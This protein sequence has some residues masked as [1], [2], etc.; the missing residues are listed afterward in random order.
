MESMPNGDPLYFF[1]DTIE[2]CLQLGRFAGYFARFSGKDKR[3]QFLVVFSHFSRWLLK[4]PEKCPTLV[5]QSVNDW[6]CYILAFPTYRRID[7]NDVT[8]TSLWWWSIGDCPKVSLFQL[9]EVLLVIHIFGFNQSIA[10]FSAMY[11]PFIV[12]CLCNHG[13]CFWIFIDVVELVNQSTSIHV[14]GHIQWLYTTAM[15]S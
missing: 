15:Y 7:F 14:N 12:Y 11:H 5:S 2:L 13:Y 3:T 10:W 4:L 8:L 9:T 1:Q 6:D